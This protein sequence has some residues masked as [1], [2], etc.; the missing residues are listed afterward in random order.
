M[1]QLL[2][3]ANQTFQQ[4]VKI[5]NDLFPVLT[6]F[7]NNYQRFGNII[8]LIGESNENLDLNSKRTVE[9]I[10]DVSSYHG[11]TMTVEE[12]LDDFHHFVIDKEGSAEIITAEQLVTILKNLLKHRKIITDNDDNDRYYHIFVGP[13][14]S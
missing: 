14:I 7:R 9:F 4:A 11:F 3:E 10:I 13:I 12:M 8:K 1:D 6:E 2:D 5:T